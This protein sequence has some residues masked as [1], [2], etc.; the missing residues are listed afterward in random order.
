LLPVLL[1]RSSGDNF[2]LWANAQT[3]AV[4]PHEAEYT[5]R[6][7]AALTR[8]DRFSVIQDAT[9]EQEERG[10]ISTTHLAFSTPPTS[11]S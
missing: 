7:H 2:R 10:L 5:S 9:Q 6:T 8:A 3:H 4:K 11:L 1:E